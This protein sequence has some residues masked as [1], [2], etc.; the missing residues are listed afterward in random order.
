MVSMVRSQTLAAMI[1]IDKNACEA[2]VV[3]LEFNS[4]FTY[5]FILYFK[6]TKT[7]NKIFVYNKITML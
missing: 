2:K 5:L 3:N 7:C 1:F 4:Y 6:L